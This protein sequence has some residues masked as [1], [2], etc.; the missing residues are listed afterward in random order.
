MRGLNGIGSPSCL[1]L[2]FSAFG[3]CYETVTRRWGLRH[4][5]DV[6]ARHRRGTELLRRSLG[7]AI[8]DSTRLRNFLCR[9]SRMAPLRVGQLPSCIAWFSEDGL[10]FARGCIS[11]R[12]RG[13]GT[14][15]L[16]RLGGQFFFRRN[17]I[18]SV[19]TT[20]RTAPYLAGNAGSV[21]RSG[22]QYLLEAQ[23]LSGVTVNGPINFT[24]PGGSTQQRSLTG[25]TNA[26]S[27]TTQDTTRNSC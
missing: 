6:G 16:P 21:T 9:C 24:R 14:C 13:T 19:C 17:Q 20:T 18:D 4:W 27:T 26:S 23:T 11:E 10:V 25:P 3:P 2:Q 12:S 7:E 1:A 8:E 22:G 5:L 15:T